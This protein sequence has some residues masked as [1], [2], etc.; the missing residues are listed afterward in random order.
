MAIII[1]IKK[2]IEK[3]KTAW[4][5]L[6]GELQIPFY[7]FAGAIITALLGTGNQLEGA[8]GLTLSSLLS[9]YIDSFVAV[10]PIAINILIVNVLLYASRRINIKSVDTD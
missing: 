4:E 8:D 9:A 2:M 3:V 5:K 10:L 7:Y 6:P 1:I